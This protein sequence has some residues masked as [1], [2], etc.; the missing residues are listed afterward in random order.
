[1]KCGR[2]PHRRE[3]WKSYLPVPAYTHLK[4]L[5]LVY[6]QGVGGCHTLIL[7][8]NFDGVQHFPARMVPEE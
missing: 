3:W 4:E 1:M 5:I 2:I 7:D 6:L 8:V